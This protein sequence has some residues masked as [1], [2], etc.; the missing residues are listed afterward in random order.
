MKIGVLGDADV[1]ADQPVGGGGEAAA[2]VL[3]GEGKQDIVGEDVGADFALDEEFGGREGDG[4]ENGGRGGGEDRSEA[5]VAGIL[6]V[7]VPVFGEVE[8]E[9]E[10]QRA[11]GVGGGDQSDGVAGGGK[12][13]AGGGLGQGG[14]G[15]QEQDQKKAHGE[16]SHGLGWG[17]IRAG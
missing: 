4:A 15:E 6:P 3:R 7:D 11:R 17:G 16:I 9:G 8:F 13:I 10:G 1:G 5:G 2:G 12:D 14:E